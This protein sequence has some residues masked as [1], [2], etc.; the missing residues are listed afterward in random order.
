[1]HARERRLQREQKLHQEATVEVHR[2]RHVAEKHEAHFLALATAIAEVDQLTAREIGAE[3]PA[4]IDAPAA[5]G[6]SPATADSP[7]QPPR[8]SQRH[9]V[10]LVQL[11]RGERR[12][13]ARGHRLELRGGRHANRLVARVALTALLPRV[14]RQR[15]AAG[16]LETGRGVLGQRGR[17][18]RLGYA[19]G[20]P[21]YA[22]EGI[23]HAIERVEVL[24]AAREDRA[25][26]DADLFTVCE[27]QLLQGPDAIGGVLGRAGQ[28][29]TPQQR[30]EPYH[31]GVE[32][33]THL[34]AWRAAGRAPSSPP[35]RAGA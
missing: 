30:R 31:R 16:A 33:A 12:E 14:E 3:R 15:L 21:G 9:A 27:I 11:I 32:A 2:A 19:V 22:P 18:Q 13:V 20:L 26:A 34:R 28:A 7:R 35:R 6:R 5:R 29:V 10:D 23:E 4:Q 1:F 17:R 25:Q 8:D 24:G